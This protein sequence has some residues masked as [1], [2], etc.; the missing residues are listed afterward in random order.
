MEDG[1][2]KSD[3]STYL[4]RLQVLYGDIKTQVVTVAVDVQSDVFSDVLVQ[5]GIESVEMVFDK[6]VVDTVD[7][8]GCAKEAFTGCPRYNRLDLNYLRCSC[9][10]GTYLFSQIFG[11]IKVFNGFANRDEF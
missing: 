1:T 11:E 9:F 3:E 8:I 4:L 10:R 5:D 6:F 7:N 2:A